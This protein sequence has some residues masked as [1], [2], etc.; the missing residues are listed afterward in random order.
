MVRGR[1][2]ALGCAIAVVALVSVTAAS[3]ADADKLQRQLT[4]AGQAIARAA[5]IHKS[6]LGP[7]WTGSIKKSE[8]TDDGTECPGYEPKESDLILIGS[9]SS[10]WQKSSPFMSFVSE[11]EVLKTPAMARLDWNRTFGPR[12]KFEACLR[13]RTAKEFRLKSDQVRVGVLPF[14]PYRAAIRAKAEIISYGVSFVYLT[15]K[16]VKVPLFLSVVCIRDGKAVT[17][18]IA[19]APFSLRSAIVAQQ[20][21]NVPF[22]LARLKAAGS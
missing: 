21:A 20:M 12:A 19:A 3:S 16:K 11:S 2:R 1:K 9:A 13:S 17:T 22:I 10:N 5:V 18:L 6:D 4:P 8:D 14:F 15:S 7:T